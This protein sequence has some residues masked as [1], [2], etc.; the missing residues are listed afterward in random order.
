MKK[1]VTLPPTFHQKPQRFGL[2]SIWKMEKSLNK[3]YETEQSYAISYSLP[4]TKDGQS[5]LN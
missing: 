3:L 5:F 2:S 4:D 1:M